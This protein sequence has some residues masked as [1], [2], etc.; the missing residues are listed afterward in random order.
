MATAD[1]GAV[2]LAELPFQN[3]KSGMLHLPLL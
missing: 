1:G 3:A 2:V